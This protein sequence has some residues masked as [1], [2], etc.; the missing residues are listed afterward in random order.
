MF[1]EITLRM[2]TKSIE[3]FKATA[4][5]NEITVSMLLENAGLLYILNNEIK[6]SLIDKDEKGNDAKVLKEVKERS[7]HKVEFSAH[8]T[9]RIYNEFVQYLGEKLKECRSEKFSCKYSINE[10]NRYPWLDISLVTGESKEEN[11]MML[12]LC[13]KKMMQAIKNNDEELCFQVTRVAMDWGDVYY[14]RGVRNGNNLEVERL[15]NIH[16]LLE[17][18]KRNYNHIIR[19]DYD[20]LEYFTTGWSIIWY[21]LNR[22]NFI[23]FS[24]RKIFALN[25]I[26]LSF[27]EEKGMAALPSIINFGQMVYQGNSRYI[28]EIK[29]V[30]TLKSKLILLRKCI[31]VFNSLKELGDITS[32]VEIDNLLYILGE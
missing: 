4:K 11:L 21:L 18:V 19:G 12:N 25:K 23:I 17:V 27:K 14:S 30:Y 10:E 16:K 32:N 13:S 26:L 9:N 29:Y 3:L 31:R 1:K 7:R 6:A 20:L 2:N 28:R 22:D 15:H 5:K 24:S 8:E